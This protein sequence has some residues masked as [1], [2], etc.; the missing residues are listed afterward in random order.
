[1]KTWLYFHVEHTV[2]NGKPFV[3]ENGWSIWLTNLNSS[4]KSWLTELRFSPI[5]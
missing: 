1:M 4:H 2:K 3:K 5:D